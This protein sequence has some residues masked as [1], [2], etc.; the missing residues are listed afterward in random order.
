MF[1]SRLLLILVNFVF[2]IIGIILGLRIILRFF[3]ANTNTPFVNWIYESSD[4]LLAPFAGMFPAT[5]IEGGFVI[6]FSAIFAL[7]VYAFIGYLIIE[8]VAVIAFRSEERI[9]RKKK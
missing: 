6:D 7:I 4:S 9:S 3:G 2:T 5:P 1:I 8:A